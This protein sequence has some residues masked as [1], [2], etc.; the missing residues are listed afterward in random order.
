MISKIEKIRVRPR[1]TSTYTSARANPLS[2]AWARRSIGMVGGSAGG[3]RRLSP[4]AGSLF[5]RR[6]QGG[7]QDLLDVHAL[8][9]ADLADHQRIE[10]LPVDPVRLLRPDH[11][12]APDRVV[13]TRG[14]RGQHLVGFD[15]AGLLHRL[16]EDVEGSV[17]G[18]RDDPGHF[19]VALLV[20]L[21][22]LP[23]LGVHEVA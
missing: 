15:R 7:R 19:P 13:R 20:L 23:D 17:V 11:E 9:A 5:L 8:P 3:G 6:L 10:E 1:A 21:T 22:E 16:R 12:A 18:Y 14:Q 4:P 2:S